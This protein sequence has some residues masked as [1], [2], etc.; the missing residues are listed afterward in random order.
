MTKT[1]KFT[2]S[3]YK[4]ASENHQ[5][6]YKYNKSTLNSTL[7]KINKN[8]DRFVEIEKIKALNS[9][10]N[11]I[12]HKMNTPL[13]I[14][15]TA[16]SFSDSELKELLKKLDNESFDANTLRND[17]VTISKSL[18]L[19]K[20]NILSSVKMLNKFRMIDVYQSYDNG[21]KFNLSK[22]ILEIVNNLKNQKEFMI[23]NYSIKT[24]F[25]EDSLI[26]SYPLAFKNI[27]ET[28]VENSIIHGFK[29]RTEGLITMKLLDNHKT[30]IFKYSD[31]GLNTDKDICRRIFEPF[32]TTSM[33]Q[34]SCGLGMNIVFNIV[35]HKMKGKIE[36]FNSLGSGLEIVITLNKRFAEDYI[37]N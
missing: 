3:S 6:N 7:Y 14:G 24:E 8:Q 21:V 18:N 11:G 27:I 13:G 16:V 31:N 10:V 26:E 5:E 34:G 36:C 23:N 25:P 22:Y 29:K 15:L 2:I 33:A 28:L 35:V 9:L 19:V 30:F 12:A 1:N 32:Y 20:N 17:L 4:D 37:G